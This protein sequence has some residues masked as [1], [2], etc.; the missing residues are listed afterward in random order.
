MHHESATTLRDRLARREVG[1]RELLEH[2]VARIAEHDGRIRAVVSLD[3]ERAR[4]RADEADR[5]LARGERWGPLHGLPMTIK[6][7]IETAGLRTTSGTKV[8]EQHVPE[9]DAP[10][11]ARLKAAGAIVFGKTNLP[12]F[13]MDT[14]SYNAL[15]GTTNNPWDPARTAGGS[16]GGAAAALA[17]G[18]TPLELGSDIAGSIRNP[19]H[20]C[21]V[22]GHKPS[23]GIV[24]QRGHVPGPPG[25]LSEAD[26][27]VL[28]PMAR[29]AA[30]LALMLDVIAGPDQPD[31]VAWQLALPPPRR[32]ALADFRVVAW[33]DEPTMPIDDELR[34]VYAALVARL[35]ERGVRVDEQRRPRLDPARALA[36]FWQLLFAATSA[37]SPREVFDSLVQMAATLAPADD[38]ANAR[39]A[40]HATQ[41]HRQWLA[42][43][44]ARLRLRESWRAFFGEADVLLCPVAASA[45]FPHDHSEPIGAR[46]IEVNGQ[47]FP[48]TDQLAWAGFVGVAGLPSTSVP[49]GRT[50]RGL[51]VGVQVVGPR[52]EDRTP[53]AFAQAL[54]EALGGFV[55]PPGW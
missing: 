27:A 55:P 1:S 50:A 48:Y 22:F 13:A 8:Y 18:F 23:W 20:Y 45:A 35:R 33:F 17:A 54:E 30:D 24:P 12:A 39:V 11:V 25:T 15:F 51:P 14:Q 29:S 53:L 38:S 31:A 21:G 28:G 36:T 49:V 46:T 10:A 26:L 47:P 16:S 7:S 34:A 40:R 44:E 32:R 4:A 52:L 42:A 3:L 43:N 5:A 41:R 6:D 37:G 19:A 2:L 9:R